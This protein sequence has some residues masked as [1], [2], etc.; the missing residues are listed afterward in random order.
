MFD[1]LSPSLLSLS[2]L[3]LLILLFLSVQV[4]KDMKIPQIRDPS[5]PS[6]ADLPESYQAKVSLCYTDTVVFFLNSGPGKHLL[7]VF[8]LFNVLLFLS[9]LCSLFLP[10]PHCTGGWNTIVDCPY[11]LWSG[12]HKLCHIPCSSWLPM[13]HNF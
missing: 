10:L 1:F 11:R 6:H 3:T 13:P 9:S 7:A 8:K 12:L 5:L 2:A 4:F